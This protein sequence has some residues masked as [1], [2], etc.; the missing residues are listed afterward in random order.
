MAG[1]ERPMAI[2]LMGAYLTQLLLFSTY[3]CWHNQREYAHAS[4][5]PVPQPLRRFAESDIIRTMG[6]TCG[7]AGG[8]GFYAPRVGS[9]FLTE[10]RLRTADGAHT[11]HHY[12]LLTT[13]EGRIRY[14][15]FTDLFS[16]LL[17]TNQPT[18]A[19]VALHRR[20]SRAVARS[21]CERIAERA[22]VAHVACHIGV[23]YPAPLRGSGAEQPPYYLQL[24]KTH[25]RP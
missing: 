12:P 15:A 16:N 25:S 1:T 10:F 14:R 24:F 22:A 2:V 17:P 20:I 13:L 8:Y 6:H 23:W 5:P 7:Y 11:V 9:H 18:S 4:W 21:L 19:S 3:S